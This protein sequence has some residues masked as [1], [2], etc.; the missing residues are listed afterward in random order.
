MREKTSL[1]EEIYSLLSSQRL[2]V[3]STVRQEGGPYTNLVAFTE[4]RDLS[5]IYF[6]TPW[7]TRKFRNL[8]QE[9]RVSMLIDNRSNRI[10]DFHKAVAVTVL[11]EA[12]T[13]PS[14][15]KEDVLQSH[16]HKHPY[17]KDFASSDSCAMVRILVHKYILV[18]RLQHVTELHLK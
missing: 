4:V 3:L 9:K 15:E 11:G 6:A 10:S 1:Q 18:E 5:C 7:T 2:G 8:L 17:L 13:V 16:L 14:D 12:E